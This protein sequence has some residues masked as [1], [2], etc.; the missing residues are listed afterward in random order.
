MFQIN[1]IITSK[2]LSKYLT[3]WYPFT[4]IAL[5]R[6][7]SKSTLLTCYVIPYIL[8]L[9]GASLQLNRFRSWHCSKIIQKKPWLDVDLLKK[10]LYVSSRVQCNI[11]KL[12]KFPQVRQVHST[13]GETV[14]SNGSYSHDLLF[15]QLFVSNYQDLKYLD[16]S[17]ITLSSTTK[18]I[19]AT[20]KI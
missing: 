14:L 13:G 6:V 16:I 3:V 2:F 15:S 12:K 5:L 11:L 9:K 20:N 8:I 10:M 1:T 7:L 18:Y 4:L 17:F 19:N